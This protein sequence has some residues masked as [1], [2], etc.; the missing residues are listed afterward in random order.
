MRWMTLAGR[1]MMLRLNV[2]E[3]ADVAVRAGVQGR[4]G[5]HHV[6]RSGRCRRRPAGQS[7]D[8]PP[9]HAHPPATGHITT[10]HYI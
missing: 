5:Q 4:L 6:H 3:G 10:V 9:R 1:M 2:F 7:T 8:P